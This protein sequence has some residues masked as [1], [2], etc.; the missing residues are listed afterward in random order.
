MGPA[1]SVSPLVTPF[2]PMD[3]SLLPSMITT[4]QISSIKEHVF[5]TSKVKL[6][7]QRRLKKREVN[8]AGEMTVKK[9]GKR[10]E[11]AKSRLFL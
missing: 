6:Q 10:E 4:K 5:R 2:P 1:A 11:L 9:E 3:R 8:T 7:G